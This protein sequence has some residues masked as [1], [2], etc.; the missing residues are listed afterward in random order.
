V[1]SVEV[2]TVVCGR[3]KIVEA[4]GRGGM[5]IVYRVEH[6]HTGEPLALKLL[7]GTARFDPQALTRFK[8]EARVS[9]RIKS[10]HVVRVSD[11]DSA[12]ELDNSPFIVMEL[13]SGIDLEKLVTRRGALEPH[14]VVSLLSQ[15][16]RALEAAHKLGIVHRDIKPENLFLHERS[17]G[18]SIAKVLDFGISKY[19]SAEA[20]L[21][22]ANMTSTGSVIG[23]PLYMAPEQAHGQNDKIDAST[24][25]WAMGLVAMRLLTGESYWGAPTMADLMMKLAVKP[26]IPPSE[27]WPQGKHMSPALDAWFL[28]SCDR[29][30]SK[31]WPSIETQMSELA[32]ALEIDVPDA[33]AR[34][35]SP[36]L[37]SLEPTPQTT[38]ESKGSSSTEQNR[39]A[40][41]TT[42]DSGAGALDRTELRP[43]DDA[44]LLSASERALTRSRETKPPTRSSRLL[45]MIGLTVLVVGGVGFFALGKNRDQGNGNIVT[46][47]TGSTTPAANAIPSATNAIPASA[48]A[49]PSMTPSASASAIAS[50]TPSAT[51]AV[52]VAPMGNFPR[53]KPRPSSSTAPT[54]PANA[55]SQQYDPVAP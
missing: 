36:S 13:L 6:V 49:A 5:G 16:G 10:E 30:Q 33:L 32:K 48:A 14:V 39:I 34:T 18:S 2:G 43:E 38:G 55:G 19:V 35:S 22:T 52:G 4:I 27:R 28:R 3:Y 7:L 12:P 50:V 37:L 21:E 40:M 11:A 15:V 42:A 46:A 20:Q 26:I 45:P 41:A 17:D 47:A 54:A 44:L 9:A 8:R 31:R 23:T 51:V 25:I 29:D 53:P 1:D 24:D